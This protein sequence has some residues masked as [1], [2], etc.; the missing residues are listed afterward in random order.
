MGKSFYK[1]KIKEMLTCLSLFAAKLM[2]LAPH[3]WFGMLYVLNSEQHG[4]KLGL[5]MTQSHYALN[6][7]FE[8]GLPPLNL[9]FTQVALYMGYAMLALSALHFINV[10]YSSS[11]LAMFSLLGFVLNTN[12][13][14]WRDTQDAYRA[15]TKEGLTLALYA[16]GLLMCAPPASCATPVKAKKNKKQKS[17]N[18][19]N[20]QSNN[21]QS[22]GKNQI[23]KAKIKRLKESNQK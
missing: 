8:L 7:R 12:A 5:L 10:S 4:Q 2:Y 19:Q 17:S 18:N 21:N 22:N 14:E 23:Q 20:V 13:F 11:M 1:K 6:T 3:V 9:D 15:F 16:V